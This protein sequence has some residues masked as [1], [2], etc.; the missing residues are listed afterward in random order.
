MKENY[1]HIEIDSLQKF[2]TESEGFV[3]NWSCKGIGF[4]QLT[5]HQ[6]EEGKFEIAHT[7][8]N[9]VNHYKE[10]EVSHIDDEGV[11]HF[12]EKEVPKAEEVEVK[13]TKE[14]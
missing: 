6:T 4:G 10:K 11:K 13:Q 9:G 12:K 5:I 8:E 1:K 7:D 14:K 2:K 3:L